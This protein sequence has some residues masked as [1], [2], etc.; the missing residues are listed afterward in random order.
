MAIGTVTSGAAFDNRITLYPRHAELVIKSDSVVFD[1]PVNIRVYGAGDI[2]VTP[3]APGMS[4]VTLTLAAGE[5]VPFMVLAVKSTG[6]T[7][8]DILAIW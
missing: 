3:A 2:V 8:A 7:A 5:D 4:D 6:T 1:G